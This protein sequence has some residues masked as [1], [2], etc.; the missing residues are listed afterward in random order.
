MDWK[1]LDICN[2]ENMF[3]Y[4]YICIF[5]I[6]IILKQWIVLN[7]HADWLVKL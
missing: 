3:R 2:V 1:R 6:S 4:I 5:N 7:A